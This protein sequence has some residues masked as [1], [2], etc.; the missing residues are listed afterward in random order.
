MEVLGSVVGKI[1]G[2]RLMTSTRGG[3]ATGG[4]RRSCRRLGFA[5]GVS[6]LGAVAAATTTTTTTALTT[7]CGGRR[8]GAA[9][10]E[11]SGVPARAFELETGC[12]QLFFEA[13]ATT[14]RT[15]RERCVR[16]FLQHVL[17]K[18]AGLAFISVN[19]HGDLARGQLAKPVIIGRWPRLEDSQVGPELHHQKAQHKTETA[20]HQAL[21]QPVGAL[22]FS[23]QIRHQAVGLRLAAL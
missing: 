1:N 15:I 21:Q 17:G 10:L 7:G 3:T 20:V 19:W 11:I 16:H 22:L 23:Q 5:A 13:A 9:T 4:C 12:G 2:K 18:P 14:T 8:C 6:R